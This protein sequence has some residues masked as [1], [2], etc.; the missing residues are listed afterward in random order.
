LIHFNHLS[1]VNCDNLN[2]SAQEESLSPCLRKKFHL[3]DPLLSDNDGLPIQIK[4]PHHMNQL[5][6]DKF[7]AT[8]P[9]FKEL[10]NELLSTQI[11]QNAKQPFPISQST[12]EALRAHVSLDEWS[13]SDSDEA[14]EKL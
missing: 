6:D 14:V 2:L 11:L 10:T 4:I 13:D 12:M 9:V 7:S 8:D 5:V 3:Q 1:T